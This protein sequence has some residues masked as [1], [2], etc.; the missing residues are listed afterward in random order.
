MKRFLSN[1]LAVAYKEA[2]VLRHDR[3]LMIT[4]LIQPVMMLLLLGYGLSNRPANVPWAVLDRSQ[5]SA[6]RRLVEEVLATG[7]FLRPEVVDGYA[8][9]RARLRRQRDIAVLVIPSDFR[10]DVARSRG[11]VQLL[12]DGSDPL[13]AARLGAYVSQVAAAFEPVPRPAPRGEPGR[14]V[15][16]P[17]D[18]RQR[19]WFNR[20]LA[21]RDF[22]LAVL[23]GTLLTN[24]CLSASSLSIV[25]ERE[26]GTYEQMLALPTSP[27]ELVIGKLVPFVA[28]S[29]GVM[30]LAILGPGL[31]FGIWPRGSLF[32]FA[33]VT[34]PFVLAS[35]SVGVFVSTLARN[36]AQAV[37]ITIF[38]I[39]PSFVLS[40]VLLPYQLMPA[41]IRALGWI[42]PLR[43][44]QVALRRIVSRGGG[45]AEVAGPFAVLT[46]LFVV[47][48][49]LLRWRMRPRLG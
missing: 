47:M 27:V 19:F 31:L 37:F 41:G 17:I 7:Y 40:G 32:A 24:F 48:L 43:W 26:S 49:L 25:G 1:V 34:L 6:S 33:A 28:V 42:T 11:Q 3:A 12:L 39:L 35:L 38:F 8:A 36:S 9:A 13:T 4:V 46:G 14:R 18:V 2:L 20:T 5:T 15:P 45:L 22:F 30:V 29:Y 16:G 21:D 44:Y 23:A 10:R